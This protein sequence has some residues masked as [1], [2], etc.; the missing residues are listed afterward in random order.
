MTD[1][2]RLTGEKL[3][4]M[5]QKAKATQLN[6]YNSLFRRAGPKPSGTNED[7]R[8]AI[9]AK[10]RY[11]MTMEYQRLFL[12][13]EDV[14]KDVQDKSNSHEPEH[15]LM[16]NL[17]ALQA[18]LMDQM[19]TLV[20]NM[21]SSDW[22]TNWAAFLTVGVGSGSPLT[23]L[24][25][26]TPEPAQD[27][28]SGRVAQRAQDKAERHGDPPR[29]SEGPTG[30]DRIL[31]LEE[32]RLAVD[33]QRS[34][35]EDYQAHLEQEERRLQIAFN[36]DMAV[37][38][39]EQNKSLKLLE[40]Y[41]R[42]EKLAEIEKLEGRLSAI[43]A[44]QMRLKEDLKTALAAA[45]EQAEVRRHMSREAAYAAHATKVPEIDG[46]SG[47]NGMEEAEQAS[48]TPV[49]GRK[50]GSKRGTTTTAAQATTGAM[51]KKK[52]KVATEA[53]ATTLRLPST[54]PDDVAGPALPSKATRPPAEPT[55]TT[56]TRP[57]KVTG[58]CHACKVVITAT[59]L[60]QCFVCMQLVHSN[61]P[62]DCCAQLLTTMGR[63]MLVCGDA[64]GA[65][66]RERVA[67][68]ALMT[69]QQVPAEAGHINSAPVS[70]AMCH[71]CG[72]PDAGT[73]GHTCVACGGRCHSIGLKPSRCKLV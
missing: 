21:P 8:I 20:Q 4:K 15:D 33:Q 1:K 3:F 54:T 11:M 47:D 70:T 26:D 50:G 44:E 59:K 41:I 61:P 39:S 49:N 35:H 31:A 30:I 62:D 73:Y 2:S 27:G 72:K 29:G 68:P 23:C 16:R 24:S 66:Q 52:K 60:A 25:L 64:C 43:T 10:E 65:I 34:E 71:G 55:T 5:A 14:T 58:V 7:D 51:K 67:V 45:G 40:V 17:L 19:D 12:R 13:H 37:L 38:E 28:S 36:A 48:A 22:C 46:G 57:L 32:R 6:V 69:R 63:H 18:D 56:T 42:L 53:A 9:V